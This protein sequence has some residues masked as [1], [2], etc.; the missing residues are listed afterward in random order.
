MD[1]KTIERVVKE[2][3]ESLILLD[4]AYWGFA[5][6]AI[7]VRRLVESYSNIIVSRTFS[8]YYGLA[9]IR[10]GY[11]FCNAKVQSIYGLD[12]PL[13]RGS[14]ISRRIAVAALKDK[15]YYKTMSEELCATRTWFM[16]E[17]NKI[18]GVRVFDSKANFVAVR[19][20]GMDMNYLKE[21]L[22]QQG[23]LIR[24]FED[25]GETIARIAIAKQDIMKKVITFIKELVKYN[26]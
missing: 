24:L 22:K 20:N 1:E 16:D 18:P 7:D 17:L 9:D 14:S 5:E 11:G 2:N 25:D 10:I 3:P 15:I 4:Q 12:L 19:I 13:F 21:E 26:G 8:K 23:I 6:E